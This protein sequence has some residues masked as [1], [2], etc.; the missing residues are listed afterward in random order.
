MTNANTRN[1]PKGIN[2]IIKVGIEMN[3]GMCTI[4]ISLY[5]LLF[6]AATVPK[7]KQPR[8]VKAHFGGGS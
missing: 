7:T 6:D 2:E 5:V 1:T 4:I 3:D 8:G